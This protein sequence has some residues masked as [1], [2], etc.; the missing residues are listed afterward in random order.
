MSYY[1]NVIHVDTAKNYSPNDHNDHKVTPL[2][3]PIA[4]ISPNTTQEK[5]SFSQRF[6]V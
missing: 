1:Q 5:I 3:V 6:P 4:S 2:T